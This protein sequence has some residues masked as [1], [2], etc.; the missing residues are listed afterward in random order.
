MTEADRLYDD[1]QRL[2]KAEYLCRQ[3]HLRARPRTI[4]VVLSN[5]CNLAC[6]HCYQAKIGDDLLTP[7]EIGRELRREL[8]SFYPYLSTLDLLGGEVFLSPG[9]PE[10]VADAAAMNHRP[11]LRITTNGTLI[12]DAWAERIVRTP[13]QDVTISID[14]GTPAT[15]RRLRRGGELETVLAGIRAIQSWKQRLGSPFP[16]L[17]SFFV[18]MRS[19]FQD[20]PQYLELMRNEGIGEVALE[21]IRIN[22]E[23]T[24][25]TPNLVNDEVI[26]AKSEVFELHS[27]LQQVLASERPHFRA[28]RVSGLTTL[29][30]AYGLDTSFLREEVDGL[31]PESDDLQSAARGFDLCPNPWTTMFITES[32]NVHICFLAE[33]IGNVYQTPLAEIWNSPQALAQRSRMI[34]GRYRDANCSEVSCSWR[35]GHV[36]ESPDPNEIVRLLG[37][38]RHLGDRIT[39]IGEEPP[40]PEIAAVRRLLQAREQ[41]SVEV[42]ALFQQYQD[43][44][45]VLHERAQ[46]HIQHLESELSRQR[47]RLGRLVEQQKHPLVKLALS[48]SKIFER[49]RRPVQPFTSPPNAAA[50]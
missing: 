49:T 44:D 6:I 7:P 16:F 21:T 4:G 26:S 34:S 15:Y 47:E 36:R 24:A 18:I 28:I 38:M 22:R 11:I 32:G 33:P 35:E 29:F 50:R 48:A 8:A 37:E 3:L 5:R 43:T 46:A 9:F 45:N 30:K 10:L 42:R 17:N 39:G 1:N 12:D 41:D 14:A 27:L 25:R 20:I 23:N 40:V 2:G 19:N 31:Y 13:F